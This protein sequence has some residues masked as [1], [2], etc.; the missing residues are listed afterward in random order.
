MRSL[1]ALSLLLLHVYYRCT[2]ILSY[3]LRVPHQ[4][5]LHVQKYITNIHYMLWVGPMLVS[6]VVSAMA[7]LPIHLGLGSVVSNNHTRLE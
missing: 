5:R 7:I 3:F 1:A 2:D 4:A 6:A